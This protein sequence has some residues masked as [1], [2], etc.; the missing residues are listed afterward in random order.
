MYIKNLVKYIHGFSVESEGEEISET[1]NIDAKL[2]DWALMID[3]DVYIAFGPQ[4][5]SE[6]MSTI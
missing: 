3:K 4:N 5:H 2:I 1:T 6:M